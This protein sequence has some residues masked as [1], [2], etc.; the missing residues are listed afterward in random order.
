[1]GKNIKNKAGKIISSARLGQDLAGPKRSGQSPMRRKSDWVRTFDAV[2]DLIAIIDNDHRIVHTNS[3]MAKAMGI[4]P[5]QCVGKNCFSYLHGLSCPPDFCPHA[6]TIKDNKEHVAEV[7]SDTLGKDFLVSTTPLFDKQGK[8]T[9]SVHVARDITESKRSEKALRQ[10]ETQDAAVQA[11]ESERKRLYNVLETLPVYVVLLDKDYRVPFANKFFRERFGESGGKRCYDYLFKRDKPCENCES[12]KAMKTN[13]TH[14]WEWT[15]PDNRNYDIYDFPFIDT[16]GS[17]MILEMGI[18]ITAQKTAEVELKRHRN[19]LEM[20]VKERTEQLSESEK[21]FRLA[22]E[23]AQDAI[24]W[25]DAKTGILIDCNVAAENLFERPKIELVG[26]HQS[27]LHPREELEKSQGLFKKQALGNQTAGELPIIT[28]SGKIK[29]VLISASIVDLGTK[30]IIQGVFRDITE[31]K[32]AEE[33]INH[34]A[35]FPQNNPNPVIEINQKGEAI[36]SNLAVSETLDRIGA[37]KKINL[38]FPADFEMILGHLR[39]GEKKIFVREVDIKGSIFLETVTILPQ[40][41]VMRI[42]AQDITA[43]KKIQKELFKLNYTLQA[44]SHSN[45]AMMRARDEDSYLKEVCKIIVK[46]CGYSMVWIGFAEENEEGGVYPVAQYGFEEGYLKTLNITWKDTECGQGP[47]GTAIRTGKLAMCVDMQKDAKFKPWRDEAVKRGY[48]SSLALPL[49]NENQTFGA[50]SIYSKEPN[51]FSQDEIALLSELAN[52][53][54]YGIS[55]I[56]MR[57]K[58]KQAEDVLRRDNETF[59]RLVKERTRDLL[60]AQLELERARRLSDIGTLAATVAHELRN[61]LAAIHMA[62]YNIKRKAQNPLLEKHL[63]VIDKKVDESDQIINN[64][65]FYSRIK[66][67][68]YERIDICAVINECVA[69]CKNRYKDKKVSIDKKYNRLKSAFVEVDPIQIREV[70]NNILN[71]AYDAIESGKG[72]VT[73]EA[74]SEDGFIKIY[75]KDSGSGIA[76]EDLKKIFDPFF[77]TKAKGTGLGLTVCAQIIKLHDGSMDITSKAG[78]GTI[79]SVKL[80]LRKGINDKADTDS[81]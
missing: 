36:F 57:L 13:S 15:G 78:K 24:V 38:F 76:Q 17:M 30:N 42:Y 33:Q 68:Q 50:L 64:L 20:L 29:I 2:P 4:A 61:P 14:H 54:A 51:G 10:R 22:F 72:K 32:L 74:E 37:S 56:R 18:D 55:Y 73:L 77:T 12:Y 45:Q 59:E 26:R 41:Q 80:P 70:F 21:K 11:K 69:S 79:V 34:L 31:R 52:D 16:D 49:V 7:H 19:N 28:K 65:L 58:Q 81:R 3:S 53:L 43:M 63:L 23:N 47:T 60:R 8:F 66:K 40:L 35:S 5:E 25:A 71:N 9:G 48:A 1:M 46:D 67:P 75:F 27:I 6:K 44:L 39:A 62:T